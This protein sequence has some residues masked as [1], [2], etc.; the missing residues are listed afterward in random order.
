M[1]AKRFRL[2]QDTSDLILLIFFPFLCVL[3]ELT[4]FFSV[5]LSWYFKEYFYCSIY[6]MKKGCTIEPLFSLM[7]IDRTRCRNSELL[8]TCSIPFLWKS[9]LQSSN[10]ENC[11][12]CICLIYKRR[13]KKKPAEDKTKENMVWSHTVLLNRSEHYLLYF[14]SFTVIQLLHP[15]VCCI[16]KVVFS[17]LAQE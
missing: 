7:W 15:S 14:I 10:A 4:A 17:R 13:K 1:K 2:V 16:V 9:S 8:L 6:M 11:K 5:C 12:D 3:R